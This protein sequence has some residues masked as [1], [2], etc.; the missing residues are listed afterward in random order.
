MQ[1]NPTPNPGK[2]RG[3]KAAAQQQRE[4]AATYHQRICKA[5]YYLSEKRGFQAGS[6]LE[7]WLEAERLVNA[8]QDE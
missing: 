4:K 6:E 8:A 7:D 1:S 5:A 3:K 2:P